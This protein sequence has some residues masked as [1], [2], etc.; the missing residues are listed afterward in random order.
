MH[1]RLPLLLTTLAA[2]PTILSHPHHDS[3]ET[4]SADEILHPEWPHRQGALGGIWG[5]HPLE[6]GET[7]G[8][9]IGGGVGG[10]G[11]VCVLTPEVMEVSVGWGLG[12][13]DW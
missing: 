5:K 13:G 9:E 3:Q 1:A 11:G 7:V 2:L 10:C 6:K 12:E 8:E 4:F